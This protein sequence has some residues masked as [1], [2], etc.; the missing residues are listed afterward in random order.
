M[1]GGNQD[2][3]VIKGQAGLGLKI[4]IPNSATANAVSPVNLALSSGLDLSFLNDS[5]SY[6]STT[7]SSLDSPQNTIFINTD[8]L[9]VIQAESITEHENGIF[10]PS[11]S[12]VL[13]LHFA[14]DG[15]H[16]EDLHNI[17]L[18]ESD[19][20]IFSDK[21]LSDHRVQF[22]LGLR[23]CMLMVTWL[24]VRWKSRNAVTE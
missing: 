20:C 17:M 13:G 1:F 10:T 19:S 2:M 22:R 6:T 14:E 16:Q 12:P 15:G 5:L 4:D 24:Q 7:P 11:S 9:R 23:L 8:F 3:E 18:D 21:L